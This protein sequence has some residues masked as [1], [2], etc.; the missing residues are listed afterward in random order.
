MPAGR[1][2][3]SRKAR[4]GLSPVI[5]FGLRASERAEVVWRAHGRCVGPLLCVEASAGAPAQFRENPKATCLPGPGSNEQVV[6]IL[7]NLLDGKEG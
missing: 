5:V 7:Q 2:R 1:V 3:H 4:V 6:A